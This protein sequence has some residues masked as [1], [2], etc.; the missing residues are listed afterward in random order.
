MNSPNSKICKASGASKIPKPYSAYNIYFRLERMYI[1]QH[2]NGS[3]D[4]ITKATIDPNHYDPLEHPIPSKYADLVLPPYWYSSIHRRQA[5]KS[6]SH[7]K[8]PEGSMSKSEM[9]SIISQRWRDVDP[10]VYQYCKKLSLAEKVKRERA[11]PK[12]KQ[13]LNGRPTTS[14]E[15]FTDDVN[16]FNVVSRDE[17]S[18]GS[19][20]G[21]SIGSGVAT[22]STQVQAG[23]HKGLE[24]TTR[25]NQVIVSS[26]IASEDFDTTLDEADLEL[27]DRA[28]SSVENEDENQLFNFLGGAL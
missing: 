24:E 11:Q 26:S 1:L 14:K 22:M 12:P 13:Q 6:R 23:F 15:S 8:K 10:E 27:F 25:G 4:D 19:I 3:M 17:A 18:G 7:K 21:S 5:E 16:I 20:T 9:N 28:V 2:E